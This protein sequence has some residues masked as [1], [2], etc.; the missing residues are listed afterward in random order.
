M[1]IRKHKSLTSRKSLEC[2]VAQ[3]AQE[4]LH[5]EY[6]DSRALLEKSLLEVSKDVTSFANADGG[7]IVYGIREKDHVPERIDDGLTSSEMTK[8]RL[9]QIILSNT[10]PK[11]DCH[12]EQIQIASGRWAF[13]VS[14]QK[15]FR[16]P[17]QDRHTKRYY[18]RR[19]FVSEPMEDYEIADVRARSHLVPSLIS[20]RTEIRSTSLLF[21][22]I[23]N[24]GDVP[25]LNVRF[26]FDKEIPWRRNEEK[27]RILET[28]VKYFAPKTRY[29]VFYGTGPQVLG[30]PAKMP[31]E[32]SVDVAYQHA[33][34]GARIREKVLVDFRDYLGLWPAKSPVLE[35]GGR[36]EDVLKRILDRLGT[37]D[38]KIEQIARV[39]APTG[40]RLSIE[41]L[42][43]VR[44][45][46][47]G[48]PGL[49]KLDPWGENHVVFSEVLGVGWNMSMLLRNHFRNSRSSKDLDKLPGMTTELLE[50]IRDAF[51][52][53]VDPEGT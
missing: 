35:V 51:L 18:K 43:N 30:N 11:V 3:K 48:K 50:Q 16:G 2:L 28:G 15:S 8:E 37:I 25:A 36:L 52:L 4:S 20:I 49:E 44:R 34:L 1:T 32:F 38:G 14:I 27:A 45:I 17:H 5:L 23:E 47:E 39:A 33:V 10:A 46:Q 26:A 7:V 29:D 22:T 19:N 42:R 12:I 24:T 41:S 40:L 9:E 53:D 13:S 6:K 21:L 31:A